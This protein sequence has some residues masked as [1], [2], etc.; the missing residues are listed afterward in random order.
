MKN[1]I[2]SSLIMI[3]LASICSAATVVPLGTSGWVAEIPSIYESSGKTFITW[4]IVL[5]DTVVIEIAKYFDSPTFEEGVGEP[6]WIKFRRTEDTSV[7]N[8][9]IKDELI[10]ND[11]NTA[12]TDFHMILV[13]Q[14]GQNNQVSFNMD[15]AFEAT[16]SNPFE[17]IYY[18]TE[19]GQIAGDGDI[20]KRIVFENGI[21]PSSSTDPFALGKD[22][23]KSNSVEIATDIEVGEFFF[24]KEFPTVP[25][26]MTLIMLSLGGIALAKRK[27]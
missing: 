4:D 27:R 9:R 23:T 13:D 8:I 16:D 11:T 19:G 12:W 20:A 6:I 22:G 3:L 14:A 26:P 24:L 10:Y 1:A 25:E 15:Y 7:S 18:Q 5:D 2:F 17:S 21:A